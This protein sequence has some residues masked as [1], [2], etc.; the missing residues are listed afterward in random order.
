MSARVAAVVT[1]VLL[2]GPSAG[3]AQEGPVSLGVV[4]GVDVADQAGDDAFSPHDR[5]GFIGGASAT[6]R[7]APRWSVQLDALFVQK[8]G[9]E[10]S[11]NDP[12]DIPDEFSVEYVAFPILLKFSLGSGGTH[13]A[14]F[15]GP[16]FAFE[17]D[18]TYDSFPDGTSTPVDCSDAGLQTRSP[19]VGIAFGADVEIPLGSG[20][21]VIDGRGVVG[22][23]SFVDSEDAGD[24]RN[25][26]LALMVGYRFG[27]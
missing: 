2:A 7:F 24:V 1:L 27:L 11:D 13:P 17:V 25:R 4:A 12:E 19:D 14:L 18:C 26:I 16:S 8:G 3:S 5:F 20:H 15:V 22:L 10:N 6:F 23:G 21:L 9:K